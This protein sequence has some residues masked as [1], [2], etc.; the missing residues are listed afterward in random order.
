MDIAK[1]TGENCELKET[2]LRFTGKSEDLQWY[3]EP[4]QKG[5]DCE[6]WITA[7]IIKNDLHNRNNSESL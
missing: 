6:Y 7:K 4:E 1:C 3:F 5:K 2:C